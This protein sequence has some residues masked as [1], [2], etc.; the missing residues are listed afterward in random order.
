M[1][2]RGVCRVPI[3]SPPNKTRSTEPRP[4]RN[5]AD[6]ADRLAK[7]KAIVQELKARPENKAVDSVWYCVAVFPLNWMFLI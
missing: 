2:M 1:R 7:A 6:M 4:G 5:I 3:P